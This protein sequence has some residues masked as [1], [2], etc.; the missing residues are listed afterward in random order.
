VAGDILSRRFGT[1][2]DLTHCEPPPGGKRLIR[3][4]FSPLPLRGRMKVGV[5]DGPTPSEQSIK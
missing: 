5:S 3:V 4:G 2:A 1:P